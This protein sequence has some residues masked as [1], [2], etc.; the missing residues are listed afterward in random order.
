MQLAVNLSTKI[1]I[2][3]EQKKKSDD[4]FANAEVGDSDSDFQAEFVDESFASANDDGDSEFEGAEFVDDS[5]ANAEAGDSEF[6][7]AEFADDSFDNANIEFY[8][9]AVTD[10][11]A[12]S[13]QPTQTTE[14][15]GWVIAVLVLFSIIVVLLL[16]IIIQIVPV[17]RGQM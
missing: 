15:Q 13:A 8:D 5:F 17:L 12:T 7:G 14:V 10:P 4:S 16:A 2:S 11:T 6:E 9:A 1:Q 3:K